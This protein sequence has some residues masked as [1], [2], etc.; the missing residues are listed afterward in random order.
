MIDLDAH[1]VGGVARRLQEDILYSYRQII[2]ES[3]YTTCL[4][5]RALSD[6]AESRKQEAE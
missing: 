4:M 1:E 5:P 3:Q 2:A 6:K